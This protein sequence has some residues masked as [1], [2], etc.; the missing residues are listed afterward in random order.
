MAA[1]AVT[2]VPMAAVSCRVPRA[3]C[4]VAEVAVPVVLVLF[5]TNTLQFVPESTLDVSSPVSCSCVATQLRR[6]R[7]SVKCIVQPQIKSSWRLLRLAHLLMCPAPWR[8]WL[9]YRVLRAVAPLM[10]AT[11]R[12]LRQ[13]KP[14]V[15]T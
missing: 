3:A 13:L 2:M 6:S 12:L 10:Y 4:P 8:K 1:A 11:M 15:H 5:G 14:P 9:P 7:L